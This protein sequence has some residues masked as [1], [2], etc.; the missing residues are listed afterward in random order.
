MQT[1]IDFKNDEIRKLRDLLN[2]RTE[3]LSVI[4][5]TEDRFRARVD[6]LEKKT[7]QLEL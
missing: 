5:F 7:R 2:E 3:K 4:G 6:E 1:D